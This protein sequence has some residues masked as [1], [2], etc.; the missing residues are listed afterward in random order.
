M[1]PFTV[2]RTSLGWGLLA[3]GVPQVAAAATD[4]TN[5]Q[6]QFNI[7]LISAISAVVV[8]LIAAI[9][10]VIST[11][12]NKSSGD[13]VS[14]V[15]IEQAK[16]ITKLETDLAERDKTITEQQATITRMNG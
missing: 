8:A 9:A 4:T 12:R 15:I 1:V 5:Y 13:D 7:G 10:T 16:K 14:A 2:I 6:Q 3:G 11:R